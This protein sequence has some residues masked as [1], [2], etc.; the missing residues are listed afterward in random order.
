MASQETQPAASSS[1]AQN[2]GSPMDTS[3]APAPATT[4]TATV[5]DEASKKD[6]ALAEFML[7]LDD[8]EPLV[9]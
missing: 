7:M 2:A 8:Y 4:S 5:V 1:N 9:C 6:R 3:S